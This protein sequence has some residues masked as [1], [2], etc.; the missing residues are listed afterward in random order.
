MNTAKLRGLIRERV[1][2]QARF[3][4]ELGISESALNEKL[5][6]RTEFKRTEILKVAEVLNEPLGAILDIF[7][8]DDFQKTG[9]DDEEGVRT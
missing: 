9:N 7:F 5:A 4:A 6:G 8:A 1:S 3:A 2:T